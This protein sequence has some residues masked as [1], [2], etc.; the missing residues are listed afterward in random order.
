MK[1]RDLEKQYR[2]T[3]KQYGITDHKTTI[4]VNKFR[5]SLLQDLLDDF[6]EAFDNNT[7]HLI[8]KIST[9]KIIEEYR[10]KLKQ[11]RNSQLSSS[12]R[13][14]LIDA[15]G[16]YLNLL[17]K[18]NRHYGHL[19]D[20]V[21]NE[22]QLI[23][24]NTLPEQ[25][26][27]VDKETQE[28]LVQFYYKTLIYLGDLARYRETHSEKRVK[29]YK[30]AR[31]FYKLSL[32]IN[33]NVGNPFNQ[34][35]VLDTYESKEISAVEMY[36]RSLVVES[37]FPTAKD[38]LKVMFQKI[39]QKQY[40][41]DQ[42]RFMEPYQ[43]NDIFDTYRF[44][45]KKDELKSILIA[46]ISILYVHQS[47]DLMELTTRFCLMTLSKQPPDE[48]YLLILRMITNKL[49]TNVTEL[50]PLVA[51]KSTGCK[52][53]F[54]V[55]T[56]YDFKGFLPLKPL[57]TNDLYKEIA[58]QSKLLVNMG[59]LYES[60]QAYTTT[61]ATL[62]LTGDLGFVNPFKLQQEWTTVYE[63]EDDTEYE[64]KQDFSWVDSLQ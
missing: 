31:K 22:L 42:E 20:H 10:K 16:Y 37:P 17:F 54:N 29:D 53:M 25:A 8:W 2:Q 30:T 23:N 34:L 11:E 19:D 62:G 15:S 46:S 51:E 43:L 48:I 6:N 35:A 26:V 40:K 9:Y 49:I 61:P 59:L 1:S 47:P 63:H 45:L 39:K 3:L 27:S 64:M 41:D 56:E 52:N 14:F 50:L 60:R 28:R 18:L 12:F 32:L 24:E 57:D 58:N 44:Q 21:L 33:P 38:N 7:E 5:E 4:I 36:F 55:P 13:L